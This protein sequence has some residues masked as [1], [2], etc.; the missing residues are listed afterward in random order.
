M[1]YKDNYRKP[2]FLALGFHA[3]LFICLFIHFASK[4]TQPAVQQ[5]N[6][7][8][9]V[10]ISQSQLNN[11]L[12]PPVPPM[13]VAKPQPPQ[14]KPVARVSEAQPGKNIAQQIQIQK[15]QQI[16]Q[17]QLQQQKAVQQA[18]QEKA[19][20][21]KVKQQQQQQEEQ[22]KKIIAQEIQQQV[23][24]QLDQTKAKQQA[25][26]KQKQLQAAKLAA[27]QMLQQEV[28]ATDD[29]QQAA[30]N[31]GEIDKYKALI[32]QALS[33]QWIVPPGAQ[34]D[35]VAKL[36]VR[37]A[38]GGM[39]ISVTIAQSSGDAALDRSA[40][41]AI[42]KASPLPVPGDPALF[43]RF[44]VINLTVKPQGITAGG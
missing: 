35:E 36:T 13:P 30:A 11:L 20:Q 25:Q 41:V 27:Q 42:L 40:R 29:A 16:K 34:D 31:Q 2:L 44:R 32:L 39:V 23:T 18:Q 43:D 14:A 24:T 21:L 10:A 7:I 5:S 38:P 28:T 26:A 12:Q 3:I 15:Q 37:V 19:K 17:Q 22:R 1:L 33:Q 9:A 4:N 6:I 8:K